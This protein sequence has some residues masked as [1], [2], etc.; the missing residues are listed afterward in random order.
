ML[1]VACPSWRLTKTTVQPVGDE[2]RGVAVPERVERE[3][4]G[5]G[6]AA[7]FDRGAEVLANVAVVEPA[8]E[9]VA[10]DDVVGPLVGGGKPVLAQELG[11]CGARITSRLPA[12][13]FRACVF[14]FAGELAMDADH[15]RRVVDVRPAEADAF[16]DCTRTPGASPWLGASARP[17]RAVVSWAAGSR[18]AGSDCGYGRCEKARRLL[19]GLPASVRATADYLMKTV[20]VVVAIAPPLVLVISARP[21][22]VPGTKRPSTVTVTE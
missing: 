8:A 3:S 19:R 6:D 11:D 15:P 17:P 12:S 16:A 13:V 20:A 10:E 14:A 1:A 18:A 5:G 22:A 21:A 7:A 2:Q 4:T 9:G